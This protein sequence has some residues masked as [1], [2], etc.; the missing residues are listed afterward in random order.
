MGAISEL[1][2]RRDFFV[3]AQRPGR[4]MRATWHPAERVA[5]LSLWQGDTCIS[6]FQL[7]ADDAVRLLALIASGLVDSEPV[8]GRSET[9]YLAT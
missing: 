2:V 1:P 4:R 6:T 8:A 3:D 5:V 9:P 7:D